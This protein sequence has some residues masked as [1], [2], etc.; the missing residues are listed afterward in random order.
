MP[1]E[2][3]Q[4]TQSVRSSEIAAGKEA[5][6]MER[7]DKFAMAFGA[8]VLQRG[9][10]RTPLALAREVVPFVDTFLAQLDK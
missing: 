10:G 2:T 1:A 3:Q 5:A 7:R 4:G 8:A 9:Q 6:R